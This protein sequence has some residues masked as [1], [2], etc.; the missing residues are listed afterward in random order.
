MKRLAAAFTLSLLTACTLHQQG[1][2]DAAQPKP[3]QVAS[4]DTT[5]HPV[6]R[7]APGGGPVVAERGIGG[8]GAP[9]LGT[10]TLVAERG[11]GGTGIGDTSTGATSFTTVSPRTA[12]SG[13]TGIV[14]IITGFASVCVDGLEVHYDASAEVN[15]EGKIA[16]VTALRAGQVVMIQAHDEAAGLQAEMI[17]IRRE[18]A[19]R[20]DAVDDATGSWSVAGQSVQVPSDAWGAGRFRQGD[21]V[22][23]S[24]LRR[25][26]GTILATR[27][28]AAPANRFSLHG[29]LIRDTGGARVGLLAL[30][31][32][33]TASLRDGQSIT[34][35]GNYKAGEPHPRALKVD[36]SPADPASPFRPLV[37]HLIIQAFVRLTDGV[38]MFNGQRVPASSTL[39]LRPGYDG[40]AFVSLDRGADGHYS[41]SSLHPTTDH[42]STSASRARSS[43]EDAIPDVNRPLRQT[44]LEPDGLNLKLSGSS[45]QIAD[46]PIMSRN[47]SLKN[48]PASTGTE[49]VLPAVEFSS[50]P[51]AAA[52]L[53]VRAPAQPAGAQAS[54]AP[55][56]AQVPEPISPPA[57]AVPAA[58]GPS[59][60]IPSAPAAPPIPAA[61]AATPASAVLDGPSAT[62]GN[63]AEHP[64]APSPD[65]DKSSTNHLMSSNTSSQPSTITTTAAARL[66]TRPHF[67][68]AAH[69]V[70]IAAP[71][72]PPTISLATETAVPASALSTL[73]TP[74]PFSVT[75]APR[76]AN[77]SSQAAASNWS[78]A[79]L[80]PDT[81]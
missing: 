72:L 73:S 48:I 24:G 47:R 61:T 3:V 11:I 35:A 40:M 27:V 78:G 76:H 34:V 13:S 80:H 12:G 75:S 69:K 22:A 39:A 57:A 74:T 49:A 33:R 66:A 19:G 52:D 26:D 62:Q 8:T 31:S 56:S 55:A 25:A 77:S 28:E 65:A 7:V 68:R 1:A 18:V 17:A 38:V 44:K 37:D 45:V 4:G 30:D 36:L 79:P 32:D 54:P 9:L 64:A 43:E 2:L 50:P 46:P 14:G 41:V 63:A 15:D 10:P 20:V 23:I 16:S 53:S 21:W 60:L 29:Q 81:R 6:C 67:S 51:P 58:I 5:A 71:K 42:P 59:A 70:A